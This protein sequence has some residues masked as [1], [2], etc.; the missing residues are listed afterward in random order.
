MDR[1]G[2]KIQPSVAKNLALESRYKKMCNNYCTSNNYCS[3]K[4]MINYH[5]LA[6]Y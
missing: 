5:V 3:M 6:M 4:I 2:Q 1:E